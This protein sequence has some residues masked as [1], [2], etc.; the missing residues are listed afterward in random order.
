LLILGLVYFPVVRIASTAITTTTTAV[1]LTLA[2][3]L[4]G[5]YLLPAQAAT[6]L[7]SGLIGVVLFI[8]IEGISQAFEVETGASVAAAGLSLFVYLNVLD[9]AFSLDGVVGAFAITSSLP[10]IIGGL[11]IGAL[12]V[13]A[14]TVSLVRARTLQALPYLEHGA[15]YAIFG[16]ALAMLATIFVPVPEIITGFIGL[17]FVTL[18]YISSRREMHNAPTLIQ[19]P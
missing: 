4:F 5:A 10:I 19:H 7:F 9:S 12:F 11:G 6:I 15:H 8:V 3:L 17:V 13:R 1:A 18:A 16:L 14:F 2:V